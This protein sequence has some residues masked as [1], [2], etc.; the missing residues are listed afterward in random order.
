MAVRL[1]DRGLTDAQAVQCRKVVLFVNLHKKNAVSLRDE[2]QHTLGK[3][4]FDVTP[5]CF[6]GRPGIFP[7]GAWDVAFSLGGDGTVLYTART[8]SPRGI[9]ILPVNLG[10]LGFITGIQTDNWLDVFNNWLGGK[11]ELSRRCMLEACVFRKGVRT[12]QFCC[13]ND[14]VICAS[15]IAK[16]ITLEA[17]SYLGDSG[18]AELGPYRCDGLIIASPTGSTA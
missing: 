9:P 16:L 2:I 7:E 15:G 14:A 4:G 11:A 17:A 1:S 6:E 13:L 3:R 12:A 5:Y 18:N 8:A 10:T